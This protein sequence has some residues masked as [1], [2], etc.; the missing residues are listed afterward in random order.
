MIR[1]RPFLPFDGKVED[2]IVIVMHLTEVNVLNT[3]I[4]SLTE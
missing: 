4:I 2:D 3:N 1:V